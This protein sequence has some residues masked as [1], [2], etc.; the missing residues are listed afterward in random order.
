MQ[1]AKNSGGKTRLC[2]V[3]KSDARVLTMGADNAAALNAGCSVPMVFTV[4][5]GAVQLQM[6]ATSSVRAAGPWLYAEMGAELCDGAQEPP[7]SMRVNDWGYLL[8]AEDLMN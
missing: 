5:A 2:F 1:Q 3:S 7:I 8:C 6:T 4:A